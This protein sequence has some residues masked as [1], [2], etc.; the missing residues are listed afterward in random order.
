[1]VL[2]K[3][4]IKTAILCA[5]V[6][7]AAVLSSCG[8]APADT[9]EEVNVFIAASL[10][11]AMEEAEKVFESENPGIDIIYNAD[12]SGTLQKQIEEGADCDIFFSAAKQQ[13]DGLSAQGYIEEER[14]LLENKLVLIKPKG[15]QTEVTGFEN[16]DKASSIALGGESVPAGMY[17]RKVFEKLGNLDSVMSGTVNEC[18]NVTAVLSAVSE[19]ANE[20]GAVYKTDAASAGDKVDIIAEAADD[21]LEEP[22]IYPVGLVKNKIT[23]EE[24][25]EET[26]KF[27][28]FLQT[29]EALNI[30]EKYGF[31]AA[32]GK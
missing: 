19:G 29:D 30:F 1:M 15:A 20:I 21:M 27:Y 12:S 31:S 22:V 23:G 9:A 14:D 10:K 5:A 8:T 13:M 2:M 26:R 4:I 16:A 18:V 6:G 24:V 28:E 32:A 11:N 7:T 25:S 17:A 3:K